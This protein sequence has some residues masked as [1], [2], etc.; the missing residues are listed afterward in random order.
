VAA[1][2]LAFLVGGHREWP[3]LAADAVVFTGL[4]GHADALWVAVLVVAT[5]AA[6]D[7]DARAIL[8][9]LL[10]SLAAIVLTVDWTILTGL[11]A[12]LAAIRAAAGL[13]RARRATV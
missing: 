6:R 1:L 2:G 11:L 3:T 4:A 12:V 8:V 10:A 5:L 13:R 9:L 7:H